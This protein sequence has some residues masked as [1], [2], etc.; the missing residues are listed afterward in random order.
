MLQTCWHVP[1]RV[2][3]ALGAA[4]FA[5][6][7]SAPAFADVAVVG[8]GAFGA[9]FNIA[10]PGNLPTYGPLPSVLLP[11]TGG[12]PFTKHLSAVHLGELASIGA[13]D[14]TTQ[15]SLGAGGSSVSS[16]AIGKV[17]L[18]GGEVSIQSITSR[19]ASATSGSTGSAVVSGLVVDGSAVNVGGSPNQVL[20]NANGIK[21]VADEVSKHDKP[22]VA[23]IAVNALHMSINRHGIVGDLRIAQARCHAEGPSVLIPEAPA[24]LVMPLTGLMVIAAAVMVARRR[25][26]QMHTPS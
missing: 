11:P 3:A 14:V 17:E 5:L 24:A 16:V 4:T 6:L 1:I 10:T 23:D 9:A 8:G 20:Y 19:C 26:D 21:I 15:G 12:G 13:M 2:V 7:S 18:F 22:N 25:P